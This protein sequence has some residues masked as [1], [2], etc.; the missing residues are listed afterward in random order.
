MQMSFPHFKNVDSEIPVS[1]RGCFCVYF[2][3]FVFKSKKFQ[4][5]NLFVQ[6]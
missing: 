4:H 1:F 5:Q 3:F 6:S 2:G